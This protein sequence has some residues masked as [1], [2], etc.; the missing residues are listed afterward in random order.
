MEQAIAGQLAAPNYAKLRSNPED[1][2][3][4]SPLRWTRADASIHR[5][6]L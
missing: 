6:S 2:R 5:S 4:R 1:L 3:S